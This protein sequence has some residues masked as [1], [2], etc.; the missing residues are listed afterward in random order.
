MDPFDN[1]LIITDYFR[2]AIVR[3]RY[4]INRETI[5]DPKKNNKNCISVPFYRQLNKSNDLPSRDRQVW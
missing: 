1:V 3:S 4:P 2:R 5:Y